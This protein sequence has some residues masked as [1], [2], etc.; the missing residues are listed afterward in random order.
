MPICPACRG[1]KKIQGMGSMG[2]VEC[3]TCK[4]TGL[5]PVSVEIITPVIKA[6]EQKVGVVQSIKI[7]TPEEIEVKTLEIKPTDSFQVALQTHES[8]NASWLAT[9]CKEEPKTEVIELVETLVLEVEEEIQPDEVKHHA[10]SNSETKF[11][12]LKRK[13]TKSAK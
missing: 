9:K 4:G 13:Y 10:S 3:K 2:E 6:P 8:G 1:Q 7:M 12:K 5:D 11:E